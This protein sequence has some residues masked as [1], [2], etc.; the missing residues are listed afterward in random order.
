MVTTTT[1]MFSHNFYFTSLKILCVL[2]FSISSIWMTVQDLNAQNPDALLESGSAAYDAGNYQKAIEDLSKYL[3]LEKDSIQ[4]PVARYLIGQS[5]YTLGN[6]DKAIPFLK[7]DPNNEFREEIKE[8]ALFHYGASNYFSGKYSP[9]IKAFKAIAYPEATKN[10]EKKAEEEDENP[11]RSYALFYLGRTLMDFGSKLKEELEKPEDAEKAWADGIKA[12]DTLVKDYPK[13]VLISDALMT[14]ATIQIFM[15]DFAGAETHLKKLKESPDGAEMAEEADYLLGYVLTQQALALLA[16]FKEEEAKAITEKAREIYRRLSESDNLIVANEAAFQLANLDFTDKN[17][18]A[19]IKGYRALK[20]KDQLITSQQERLAD[21]RRRMAGASPGRVVQLQRA[22]KREEQKLNAVRSN[23]E[24]SNEAWIKIGEAYMQMREYNKARVVFR[25]ATQFAE[26]DQKKRLE[27]QIIISHAAQGN[28]DRADALFAEFRKAYPNDELAQSV[29][30]LL[31]TA[32]M[33]Q[34]RYDEALKAFNES[35]K[36]FPESP[37]SAQ[38]P[39]LKA[40][41]LAKQGKKDEAIQS[42]RDF[43]KDAEAGK[44][45]V[46]PAVIEDTRRLLATTLYGQEKHDEAIKILKDLS[47]NATTP[48]IKESSSLQLA[49]IYSQLG[50]NEEAISAFKSYA[51]NFP[52]SA[53]AAKAVYQAGA[54][55]EKIGKV[56]E[57]RTT[58]QSII[59]R[60]GDS[61]M[62]IFAYDKIWRSYK[63]NPEQMFA[64]QDALIA[65]FPDSD[66]ALVALFERA[67][68]YDKEQKDYVKATEAYMS[69]YEKAMNSPSSSNRKSQLASFSL[70]S[71]ADIKQ[72]QATSLGNY[73]ELDDAGK[74]QWAALIRESADLYLKTVKEFHGTRTAAVAMSKWS[75]VALN[76]I[77]N[78]INTVEEIMNQMSELA[79]QM[80]TEQSRLQVLIAQAGLRNERGD[81]QIALSLYDQAFSQV[82]DMKIVAWQD[83]SRYGDLLLE[84]EEWEKALKIFQQL[85]ANASPNNKHALASAVYGQGAANQGLGNSAEA[86]KFFAELQEKYPWS[87]KILEARYG[88]A[89]ALFNEGKLQKSIDVLKE[90]ISSSASNNESKAKSMILMARCLEGMAEAG[91]TTPET[92][93]EDGTDMD[94]LDLACNYLEKVEV[95]F[96]DALPVLSSEALYRAVAIRK[97]Q[98]QEEKARKI[99]DWLLTEYGTT[100]WGQQ[101]RKDF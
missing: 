42:F 9:A 52:E 62:A 63:G 33:Q 40:Q 75:K 37:N 50:K 7:E 39:K 43:I 79:G 51:N 49:T 64:A 16:D 27:V 17:Y 38:I 4:V 56:D 20:S 22:I 31:G 99:L 92:K 44:I 91:Q 68:S 69:V 46:A 78:E 61:D 98:N 88:N 96:A 23:P 25:H 15:E 2:F 26:P 80:P 57:A 48:S 71:I 90:I 73:R 58:F 14:K 11:I 83:L 1:K 82:K 3:E 70:I 45:K 94:P 77:G 32:F 76:L 18:E 65:A 5:H 81:T 10:G 93:Q 85:G 21:Y 100:R 35:L 74:Q 34:E 86:Q 29:K 59:D 28:A 66:Q 54:L 41:I 24:L 6:Y 89:L 97:K 60:F 95:M 47:A 72:K 19:A 55:E 36:E 13:S 84:A 30:F 12:L 53:T 67:K 8:S 87:P 101:A